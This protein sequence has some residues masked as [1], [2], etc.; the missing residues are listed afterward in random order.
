MFYTN[1]NETQIGMVIIIMDKLEL[2]QEILSN[3]KKDITI[4]CLTYKEYS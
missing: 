1:I 3:I 2:Q 4:Q